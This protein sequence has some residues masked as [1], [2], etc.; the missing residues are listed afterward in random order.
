MGVVCSLSFVSSTATHI[1]STHTQPKR[2]SKQNRVNSLIVD[3]NGL[4]QIFGFYVCC[5]SSVA[6][7]DA[8][9]QVFYAVKSSTKITMRHH[10]QRTTYIFA[11]S[12]EC[13]V[14]IEFDNGNGMAMKQTSNPFLSSCLSLLSL[15]RIHSTRLPEKPKHNNPWTFRKSPMSS[16]LDSNWPTHTLFWQ[17]PKMIRC[18]RSLKSV[19]LVKIGKYAPIL[20]QI[21][22]EDPKLNRQLTNT[23]ILWKL[24]SARHKMNSS[25]GVSSM[26]CDGIR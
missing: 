4:F 8:N 15:L 2:Q 26:R 17:Q 3:D 1:E 5:V 11:C 22:K 14:R 23:E 16:R 19:T 6:R 12:I 7:G 18:S 25:F 24:S 20:N 21:S 9:Y 13:W 10:Q